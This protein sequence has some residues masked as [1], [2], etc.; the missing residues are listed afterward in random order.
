[1][2]AGG[3]GWHNTYGT[4]KGKDTITS[5]LEG[6][7][8][9]TPIQWDNSF[10][11]TL[12]GFDWELTESPAG[13]KQWKP[14]D[15]AASDLVPDAHQANVR[16]APMMATTDLAL[17]MDPIYEPISRRFMENPDQLGDAFA[18]AWY[19]LLHRDM[20]PAIA[21][22]GAVGSRSATVARPSPGR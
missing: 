11:E 15:G 9:P 14:K 7:W 18:R 17:R 22:P 4:G 20:G 16:H 8:T 1:M 10:F 3:L 2:H 12:F 13:A 19:K 5:G 21:L 6:A